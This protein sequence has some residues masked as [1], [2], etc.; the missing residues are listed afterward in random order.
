MTILN[1][2]EERQLLDGLM[3][4]GE[5]HHRQ[6]SASGFAQNNGHNN[7]NSC[8]APPIGSRFCRR[9]VSC[10]PHPLTLLPPLIHLFDS[11][12]HF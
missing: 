2:L 12:V 8:C 3:S 4:T 6:T 11:P 1:S 5:H 7:T 10:S 9:R